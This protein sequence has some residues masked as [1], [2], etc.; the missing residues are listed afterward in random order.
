MKRSQTRLA[1]AF[2]VVPFGTDL[3]QQACPLC[4]LHLVMGSFLMPR[5]TLGENLLEDWTPQLLAEAGPS[6][7]RSS[8]GKHDGDN[9]AVKGKSLSEDHH[10][11]EGDQDI[12]LSVTTDTSISDDTNAKSSGEGRESTA[13]AGAKLS[14][15]GIVGVAPLGGITE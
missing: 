1:S 7:A 11:N 4:L 12:S 6:L 13:E 5:S 3:L 2:V 9:E 14:V 15:P 8:R 10:K